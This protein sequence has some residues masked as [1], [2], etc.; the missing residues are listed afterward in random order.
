[1]MEAVEKEKM[2]KLEAERKKEAE[3]EARIRK[4]IELENKQRNG[5]VIKKQKVPSQDLPPIL[6]QQENEYGDY[7]YMFGY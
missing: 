2:R 5:Q 4:K 1:M 3:I 6:Q 7:A